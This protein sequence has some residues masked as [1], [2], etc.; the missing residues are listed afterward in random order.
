VH[1]WCYD[2]FPTAAYLDIRSPESQSG[3]S[4]CLDLVELLCGD[5]CRINGGEPKTVF[6]QL[7]GDGEITQDEKADPPP[8]PILLDDSQHTFAPS[9]R[10]PLVALLNPGSRRRS[11]YPFGGRQYSAFGPKAFAGNARLPGSLAA[12]CIPILLWRK[13]PSDKIS[14][15]NF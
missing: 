10:Q 3:K 2:A 7:L 5:P 4:L 15:F 6:H 13:K 14:R 8:C 1:I 12:R 9:E 11:V